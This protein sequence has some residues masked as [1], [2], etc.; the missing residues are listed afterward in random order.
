MFPVMSESSFQAHPSSRGGL[1][2]ANATLTRSTPIDATA[3]RC[4]PTKQARPTAAETSLCLAGPFGV[5]KRYNYKTIAGGTATGCPAA[6]TRL[7]CEVWG[8]TGS[9]RRI[10]GERQTARL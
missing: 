4:F 5:A 6:M 2:K 7:R 3:V 8:A 1:Y 9:A 10:V